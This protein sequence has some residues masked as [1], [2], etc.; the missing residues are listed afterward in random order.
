MSRII[1]V[2]SLLAIA[3]VSG[4]CSNDS[5]PISSND[6]YRSGEAARLK[7]SN[8]RAYDA[9]AS[10][11]TRSSYGDSN[12]NADSGSRSGYSSGASGSDWNNRNDADSASRTPRNGAPASS[13]N[14]WNARND[15]DSNSHASRDGGSGRTDINAN[16]WGDRTW[17][18]QEI[19]MI[20]ESEM[21]N[22]ARTCLTRESGGSALSETGRGTWNGKPAYCAKVTRNGRSY[23]VVSDADGSLIAMRRLD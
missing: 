14:D 10:D 20:N 9:N 18:D 7:A 13:S 6:S 5:R 21:P 16:S 12:R 22:N 23:K 11:R 1:S 19:V 3:L 17:N 2:G 8:E 15:P 4:A